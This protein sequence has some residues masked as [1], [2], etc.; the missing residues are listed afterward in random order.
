[1][2]RYKKFMMLTALILCMTTFISCSDSNIESEEKVTISLMHGWGGTLKNH[3]TMQKIYDEFNKRNDDIEL[4]YMPFPDAKIAVE[5]ANNMLAVGK[6]PDIISTNGF[7]YYEQNAVKKGMALDLKPYILKDKELGGLVSK[8]VIDVWENEGKL[9]TIPDAIEV[10]GYWYN[11]E[12]FIK[13]GVV[14]ESGQ[15]AL[16]KTWDEFFNVCSKIKLWSEIENNSI[17]VAALESDQ[18][19][20]NFFF[21]RLAGVDK[22]GL[23]MVTTIPEDFSNRS[24]EEVVEDIGKLYDFSIEVNSIDNA[25]Q[26]FKEGKTAIYFNGVWDSDYFVDDEI[27]G[28]IGYAAYPSESGKSI[29]YV[30]PSSGYVIHDNLD[31]KKN[32][33]CIRFLKYML[34]DEVQTE[35]ALSTGQAPSSPRVDSDTIKS[36]YKLLGTGIEVAMDA[37]IHIKSM[38]SVWSGAHSDILS[39]YLLQCYNDEE[40]YLEMINRLNKTTKELE[41]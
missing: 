23:K 14:D 8:D 5:K 29:S 25:R 7:S 16:P 24:I 13:A 19:V 9:Y 17:S 30:S 38:R 28:K 2:N 21:A 3:Q 36:E 6:M 18:V 35:I 41:E 33:A 22:E 37:D 15:I 12:I 31:G 1:M 39:E 34:S 10:M 4:I 27:E 32:E 40:K 20:E 26:T 11:K